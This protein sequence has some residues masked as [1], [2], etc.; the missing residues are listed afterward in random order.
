MRSRLCPPD[1]VNRVN[2]AHSPMCPAALSRRPVGGGRTAKLALMGVGPTR[3]AQTPKLGPFEKCPQCLWCGAT[4]NYPVDK[5][6]WMTILSIY[7]ID[8]T[9][10]ASLRGSLLT[11]GK[12]AGITAGLGCATWIF[13]SHFEGRADA[14]REAEWRSRT[15]AILA[16]PTPVARAV[17]DG[18]D[19]AIDTE[20]SAGQVADSIDHAVRRVGLTHVSIAASDRQ[21]LYWTVF[22]LV[23]RGYDQNEI[24]LLLGESHDGC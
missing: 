7:K 19:I 13:Q 22:E 21:S 3:R 10:N 15:D 1:S 17:R 20:G 12:M 16:R 5:R 18:S 8:M 6:R 24:L 14:A 2:D 11:L 4:K 23:R 9:V